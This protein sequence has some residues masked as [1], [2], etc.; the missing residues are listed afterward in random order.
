MLLK[1][2]VDSETAKELGRM[3]KADH[4]QPKKSLDEY[5]ARKRDITSFCVV[6]RTSAEI[7]DQFGY[8]RGS[9]S[10]ILR[11]L[12]DERKITRIGRKYQSV[13]TRSLTEPEKVVMNIPTDTEKYLERLETNARDYAWEFTANADAIKHF[14]NWSKGKI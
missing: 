10:A 2:K 4:E 6:P 1:E 9:S 11:R 13:I 14:L 7:D 8:M 12:R 3:A 5:E